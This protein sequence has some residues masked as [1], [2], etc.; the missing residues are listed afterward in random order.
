MLEDEYSIPNN[1]RRI[2]LAEEKMNIFRL[3]QREHIDI[4]VYY[5]YLKNVIEKLNTLKRTKI[6]AYDHSSVFS[7]IHKEIF[8]FDNSIYETYKECKYVISLV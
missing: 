3:I 4:F 1:T 7:W 2:F 8:D 6:I 5:F